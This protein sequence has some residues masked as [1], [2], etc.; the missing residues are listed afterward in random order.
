MEIREAENS[1]LLGALPEL[2]AHA[3]KAGTKA[4]MFSVE[5]QGQIVAAALLHVGGCLVIT[6]ASPEMVN[7]LAAGLLHARC[8][9]TSVYGPAHVSGQFGRLWAQWTK[10]QF[11]IDRAERVYQ[12]ARLTYT[13][14]E[15]GRLELATAADSVLVTTWLEKFTRESALEHVDTAGVRDSLLANKQLYLWKNPEPVA[16]AAWVSP[17]PNGGCINLV[18]TP[19]ELRG[20]GHGAAVV[21]A[22]GRHMLSNGKRFCFILSD[23]ANHL[24][25]A[26][27]QKVGAR[28]I[29][30]L[31]RCTIV[32]AMGQACL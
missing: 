16:M 17:T 21:A 15:T 31:M 20:K 4:R 13:P 2:I 5:D 29:C 8:Q 32:P 11:A 26:L 14:P 3:D 23:P 25:H 9:I 1:Y 19:P 27:Y 28:T 12:L 24:T 30:E 18:F 6:W 22:L 10:Q 7:T